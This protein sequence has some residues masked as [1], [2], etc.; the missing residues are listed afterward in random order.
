MEKLMRRFT[1]LS[2]GWCALGQYSWQA[3]DRIKGE[4]T[5]LSR[6]NASRSNIFK[7]PQS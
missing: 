1:K 4:A 3:I 7:L 6:E 5:I 2:Q